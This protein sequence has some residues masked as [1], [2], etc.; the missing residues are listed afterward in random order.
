ME[1]TEEE[2]KA[3]LVETREKL[4]NIIECLFELG[5]L[6]SDTEETDLAK[7]ALNFKF[8]QT[9]T[10]LN[11]LLNFKR[12]ELSSVKIPLDIIQYIDMGR[13][14]NI[15]TREFVESTRKMNQYL[16]GKMTAMKLFRDTLSD[17]IILEFPELT[18]TV[19]GVVERTSPNNN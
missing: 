3:A 12:N 13:N 14:P 2:L 8:E 4:F 5:I 1:Y 6:V 18:D 11:Q 9:V 16:R 19:N 15:Y 7:R 17:K 10:N